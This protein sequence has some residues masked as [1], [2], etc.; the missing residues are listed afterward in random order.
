VQNY[1]TENR[2]FK[3]SQ[4]DQTIWDRRN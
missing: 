3:A 4:Q 2:V 1:L